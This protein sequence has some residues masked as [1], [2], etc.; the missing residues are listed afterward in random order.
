MTSCQ[1]WVPPAYN[2]RAKGPPEPQRHWVGWRWWA[3]EASRPAVTRV[4][5]HHH[6]RP[7]LGP[8]TA[9]LPLPRCAGQPKP[10]R[11]LFSGLKKLPQFPINFRVGRAPGAW[12]VQMPRVDDR[13]TYYSTMLP[14]YS[15][16][17]HQ[18]II[19]EVVLYVTLSQLTWQKAGTLH[20]HAAST[21]FA[22]LLAVRIK[23]PQGFIF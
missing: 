11:S 3:G 19:F 7:G 10:P 17:L 12:G 15:V 1:F 18:T 20:L 4:L 16:V 5:Y 6:A 13:I 14:H 2:F 8:A 9:F 23:I 22:G 21:K